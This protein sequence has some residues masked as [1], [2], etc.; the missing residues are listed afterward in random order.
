MLVD[1][2]RGSAL[3]PQIT[4]STASAVPTAMDKYV[5]SRQQGPEEGIAILT[6]RY[7]GTDGSAES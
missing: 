4:S 7:A 2:T 5:V 3:S 1:S 6:Y